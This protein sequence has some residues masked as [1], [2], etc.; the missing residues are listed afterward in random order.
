MKNNVYFWDNRRAAKKPAKKPI[1]KTLLI[2]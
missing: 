1:E 2:L